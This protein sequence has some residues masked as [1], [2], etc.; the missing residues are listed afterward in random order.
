MYHLTRLP[1]LEFINN[2]KRDFDEEAL[3]CAFTEGN[4]YHFSVILKDI[5]C[6]GRIVYSQKMGHFMLEFEG[7]YYDITGRVD[8]DGVMYFDTMYYEDPLLYNELLRDC[9]LK[10]DYF[11]RINNPYCKDIGTAC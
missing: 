5:Y 11:P 7:G 8:A 2:F 1:I 6:E 10:I 9:V 4:C 3:I